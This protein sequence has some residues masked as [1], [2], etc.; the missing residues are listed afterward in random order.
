MLEEEKKSKAQ[1]RV[2]AA[3][4]EGP[5]H[6]SRFIKVVRMLFCWPVGETFKGKE[7]ES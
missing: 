5:H 1:K 7:T 4:Q 2:M 6:E 3:D